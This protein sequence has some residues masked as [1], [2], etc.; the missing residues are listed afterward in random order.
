M[1]NSNPTEQLSFDTGSL[2]S[3]AEGPY[4]PA[5]G[6]IRVPHVPQTNWAFRIKQN[7]LFLLMVLFALG[8]AA[9]LYLVG[10]DS[11]ARKNDFQFF[12][13]SS[14]YIL[15]YNRDIFSSFTD[16]VTVSQNYL[17]PLVV[18]KLLGGNIYLVMLLNV[19]LFYHSIIRIAT[20]LD[21]DPLKVG[22]LL[23]LSPITI[24]SLLS[25]NKE[26]FVL[27][28]IALALTGY[29][30]RSVMWL[31]FALLMSILVRWEFTAFFLVLLALSPMSV[32]R[33]KLS[34]LPMSLLKRRGLVLVCLLVV[35]SVF[36]VLMADTLAP[37]I[38]VVEKSVLEDS[39]PGSGLFTLLV[40]YQSQ[41]LY[42]LVFPFKALHLL[43][44][45]G[46]RL[47]RFLN[48]RDIYNDIFIVLHCD[49]TLIMFLLIVRRRMFTLRSDLVFLSCVFL[50]VFCL[51]PVYAPRYLYPV[52]VVW[53]LVIAG[54]PM[55][56]VAGPK[57]SRKE[58]R[59]MRVRQSLVSAE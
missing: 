53:V 54:A 43:F 46:L 2:A 42:F 36:Y 35:G 24:S 4:T 38:S 17:G 16:L 39:D 14:T 15:A 44:A 55:S 40:Y 56:I 28:F 45:M 25:I 10:A 57:R 29:L 31:V 58:N 5:A 32:L 34:T 7:Q 11:L 13:D 26:I 30:R 48:P 47:D 1:T 9:F 50:A 21:L 52:Y 6:R 3:G 49:A 12:A 20:L 51:T 27:P 18:L 59:Q 37:L 41:G 23:L 33:R 22:G 19:Y 8:G